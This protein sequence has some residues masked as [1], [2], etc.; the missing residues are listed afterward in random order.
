MEEYDNI[1]ARYQQTR[2]VC[3]EMS[4]ALM[5]FCKPVVKQAAMELGVWSMETIVMDMDQMHVLMDFAIHHRF[6]GKRNGAERYCGEYP[7]A[8][9]SDAEMAQ[10]AM[11]NSFFSLF[12]VNKV[13][14]DVG[15]RVTD[16]LRDQEYFLADVNLSNSA[17]EGVVLASRVLPFEDFIMTTGA[18]L[19]V[20]ATI[21][22]WIAEN[23]DYNGLS[24]DD[25]RNL[26]QDGWSQIEA[27]IIRACLNTD[28][29]RRIEYK[30]SPENDV[31]T[32]SRD[33]DR[34]GRNEPCPCGSGKKYKK[35]CGR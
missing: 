4:N 26:S 17:V 6:K 12:Q 33:S 16:I 27:S 2:S 32:I 3:L 1:S 15:I 35:C 5:E 31:A 14:Q 28:G 34:I 24:H 7:A 8:A 23:L 20:N 13:V 25:M 30:D 29:D 19:P 21:L 18:P 22:K 11:G 10:T 9:G